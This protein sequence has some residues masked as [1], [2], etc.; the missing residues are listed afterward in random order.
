MVDRG[1]SSTLVMVLPTEATASLAEGLANELLARRLVAC[2]SLQQIQSHYCWQGKLE[3]AQE[4]QL[5][6]KTSQDQLDAL[7]QTIKELHSY[8]TPEWIY[9]SATASDPYAAWVAAAVEPV[10][11]V[12]EPFN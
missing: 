7:H 5:L 2:V 11:G 6:I 10:E 4:V 3:R 9:W 1:S 8:E 12:K